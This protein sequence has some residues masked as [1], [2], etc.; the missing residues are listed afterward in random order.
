VESA[1]IFEETILNLIGELTVLQKIRLLGCSLS[2]FEHE[3]E[4]KNTMV[5]QLTLGF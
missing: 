1:A 3:E 2:N 4:K 5:Q